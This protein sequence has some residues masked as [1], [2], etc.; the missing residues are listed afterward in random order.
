MQY[1]PHT[2][3][4]IWNGII[5]QILSSSFA[6]ASSTTNFQTFIF[7]YDAIIDRRLS[8]SIV[9]LPLLRLSTS[10][11]MASLLTE[12]CHLHWHHAVILNCHIIAEIRHRFLLMTMV[13]Q[14][15]IFVIYPLEIGIL[16][17]HTIITDRAVIHNCN[18]SFIDRRLSASFAMTYYWQESSSFTLTVILI[19]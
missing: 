9:M 10:F 18:V 8:F 4:L 3:I 11:D 7:V 1:W 5:D 2:V 12:G 15:V 19:C 6:M 13:W 14:M 16:I 17:K